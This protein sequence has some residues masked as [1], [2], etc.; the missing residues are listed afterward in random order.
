MIHAAA[1]GRPEERE[2]FVHRY[3]PPVRAYFAARW[4]DR[5]Q[6]RDVEDAVQ[7]VFLECFRPGG[8]LDRIDAGRGHGFRA[9]FFGIARHVALRF[10]ERGR[11][12]RAREGGEPDAL[13]AIA[14]GG[15]GPEAVFEK[16]WAREMV[17]EAAA[18]M[19]RVAAGKGREARKRVELL[20]LR[21][22]E[23]LP[24]REIARIWGVDPARLHHEYAQARKEFRSSLA[25]VV[26]FH[27]PH[28]DG[29]VEEE[30]ARLIAL[31]S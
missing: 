10:E 17:K 2:A 12:R 5:A 16:A 9:F 19:D 28:A 25:E 30:C 24:I 15:P 11:F 26:G 6:V 27:Q 23:G 3:A 18:A 7:D 14:D 8:A 20:H 1:G 4:R 13:A 21:F 31:L 29:G 22:Y